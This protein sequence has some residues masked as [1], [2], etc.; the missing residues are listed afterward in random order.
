[1]TVRHGE[2]GWAMIWAC[3]LLV[4]AGTLAA[5]LLERDQT[6]RREAVNDATALQAFHAV[7]GGLAHVRH[8][9]ARDPEY[10]GAPLKVGA[11]DLH[12]T[13]RRTAANTWSTEIRA[14][15]R[16]AGL[17]ATLQG[18]PGLPGVKARSALR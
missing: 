17:R 3:A 9:L 1:M 14:P 16:G 11:V 13:V 8:T 18:R 7:E 5:V 15:G 4:S 6:M 12:I 2:R 10:R